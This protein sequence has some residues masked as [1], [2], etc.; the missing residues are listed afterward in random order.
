MGTSMLLIADD[1]AW[2]FSAES[3]IA[4]ATRL[5]P[6][7]DVRPVPSEVYS[8]QVA[9]AARTLTVRIGPKLVS[10]QTS[11]D[12]NDCGRLAFEV[13]Q[14]LPPMTRAHYLDSGNGHALLVDPSTPLATYFTILDAPPLS[15]E[16]GD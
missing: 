5:W 6:T 1:P 14:G 8:H 2:R 13:V 11:L 3:V 12:L 4:A 7:A 15:R 16:E 9:I 10:M